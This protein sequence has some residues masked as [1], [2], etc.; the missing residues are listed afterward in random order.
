MKILNSI[1]IVVVALILMSPVISISQQDFV[2][3]SP[4]VAAI[5]KFIDVPVNGYTG[6]PSIN[7]PLTNLNSKSLNIPV[8]ISYHAGGVKVAEEASEVGL[9][10]SLNAGGVISREI[11]GEDDFGDFKYRACQSSNNG[12]FN[13]T[14]YYPADPDQQAG[15]AQYF[16]PENNFAM[17]F[18]SEET[19]TSSYWNACSYD[20]YSGNNVLFSDL[21]FYDQYDFESDIYSFSFLGESGKFVFDKNGEI[22]TLNNPSVKVELI[23]YSYWRITLPNGIEGTFGADTSS[24]QKTYITNNTVVFDG[25]YESCPTC[26]SGTCEEEFISAWKINGIKSPDGDE[27]LFNYVKTNKIVAPIPSYSENQ[28]QTIGNC[29]YYT[30]EGV[31]NSVSSNCN[32]APPP[33]T[34]TKSFTE[35]KYDRIE[36]TSIQSNEIDCKVDFSYATRSDLSGGTRLT[37]I[38]KKINGSVYQ[39]VALA[40]NGYFESLSASNNW[41]TNFSTVFPYILNGLYSDETLKKRLKLTSIQTIGHD[42]T[43]LPPTVFSYNDNFPIP[44]KASFEVDLWGFYNGASGNTSLLPEVKG[45]SPTIAN[46]SITQGL[47]QSDDY[48]N[49]T[50]LLSCLYIDEAGADREPDAQYASTWI[51]EQVQ[52]PSG[53]IQDFTFESN[54][55]K[56]ELD[57]ET[58]IAKTASVYRTIWS[59]GTTVEY[60]SDT[61]NTFQ[62]NNGCSSTTI[63]LV[64]NWQ[65]YVPGTCIEDFCNCAPLGDCLCST[66]TSGSIFKIQLFRNEGGAQTLIHEVSPSWI[67]PTTT[68]TNNIGSYES[69]TFS[70]EVLVENANTADSF[71]LKILNQWSPSACSEEIPKNISVTTVANWTDVGS[72]NVDVMGGGLRIESITETDMADG[73]KIKRSFDYSSDKGLTSGRSL[74]HPLSWSIN[75]SLNMCDSGISDADLALL[76]IILNRYSSPYK[77]TSNR[78]AG[79]YV[80]YEDV[81]ITT[82]VDYNQGVFSLIENQRF[83]I[84]SEDPDYQLSPDYE[85]VFDFRNGRMLSSFK[86]D[87]ENKPMEKVTYNYSNLNLGE[88]W[89]GKVNFLWKLSNQAPCY[90]EFFY[91][92]FNKIKSQ[93]VRLDSKESIKYEKD[94]G[95]MT[96]TEDYTY[97]ENYFQRRSTIVSNGTYSRSTNSIYPF[98]IPAYQFMVDANMIAVPLET[99]IDGG[100][101]GG[102]KMNFIQIGDAVLPST[103]YVYDSSEP[104]NWKQ[105]QDIVSYDVKLYPKIIKN[106]TDATT[107]EIIWGSGTRKGLVDQIKY[108]DRVYSFGYNNFRELTSSIDNNGIESTFSYDGLGRLTYQSSNNGRVS[109]TFNYTIDLV[110]GGENKITNVL[111]YGDGGGYTTISTLDGHGRSFHDRMVAYLDDGSNLD[112]STTHD[113]L[114]RK[115]TID[116]PRSGGKS[117]FVPYKAPSNKVTSV[118]PAGS[119]VSVNTLFTTDGTDFI[120]ETIDE[121]GIS[122]KVHTDIFGN[123]RKTIDGMGEA[124]IYTYNNRD[125]VTSIDPPGSGASYVYSYYGDGLLQSKTIPDKGS[126]IYTYDAFDQVATETLPNGKVVVNTYHGTYTDFLISR[127]VDG[128]LIEHYKPYDPTYVKDFIGEESYSIHTSFGVAGQRHEI[129]HLDI[130]QDFGRSITQ[131]VNTLDGE[132]LKEMSYDDTGNMTSNKITTTAF[133]ET[134]VSS[135][136]WTYPKG[137]RQKLYGFTVGELSGGSWMNYDGHDWLTEKKLG[138]DIQIVSYEYNPR[139]WLT[140]INGIGDVS[141]FGASNCSE[142]VDIPT[143]E[144]DCPK[145]LEI[146]QTFLIEYDCGKLNNG[147]PTVISIGVTSQSFDNGQRVGVDHQTITI[148]V[149]GASSE[150]TETLSNSFSFDLPSVGTPTEISGGI[151]ELLLECLQANPELLPILE[152]LLLQGLEDQLDDGDGTTGGPVNTSGLIHTTKPMFGMEIHYFDGNGKLEAPGRKNGNIS[153]IEWQVFG[154]TPNAYGFDY[155]D[156]NRLLQAIHGEQFE[157]DGCAIK[158]IDKYSVTGIGY[159]E[160]GNIQTLNRKGLLNPDATGG[161]EYK[162]IDALEYKYSGSPN[163]VSSITDNAVVDKGFVGG[164]GSYNYSGTGNIEYMSNK[165]LDIVYA[166]NDLPVKMTNSNGKVINYYTSTGLK[167]KTVMEPNEDAPTGSSPIVTNYFE[168]QEFQNSRLNSIYFEEGRATYEEFPETEDDEEYIEYFL[169]DHL[170]NTRVRIADKNGDGKVKYDVNNPTNDELMSKHH[171]YPFGM[172]WDVPNFDSNGNSLSGIG[173]KTKYTYNGKELVDDLD[174]NLNDYGARYYD[175]AIARFTTIDPAAEEYAPISGYSYVANNPIIFTDP[176]GAYIVDQDGNRVSVTENE[177]GSTSL[178]GNLDEGSSKILNAMLTTP[179]GLDAVNEMLISDD[180]IRLELTDEVITDDKGNGVHGMTTSENNENG[181]FSHY[182]I[183]VSTA[184]L[185]DDRMDNFSDEEKMNIIGVHEEDHILGGGKLLHNEVDPVSTELQSRFEYSNLYPSKSDK[186]SNWKPRYQ[187]YLGKKAVKKIEKKANKR[188]GN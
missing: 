134:V 16:G 159:D 121:D 25:Q 97:D 27:V 166:F 110:N 57:S 14:T 124:T 61:E 168:G 66:N 125:L 76:S 139:G 113:A 79:S 147:D 104:T 100:A 75:T 149:N 140:K 36:L 115:E 105:V 80:G 17:I 24:I 71:T 5:N 117:T 21:C 174:I 18:P 42:G 52:N 78:Y 47:I 48:Q 49:C 188:T 145:L 60:S 143:P 10:W 136:S 167:L 9:G 152:S 144:L 99:R 128:T 183:K 53:V 55:Y 44:D 111:A 142:P 15:T 39:T 129:Q 88:E 101:G 31:F 170:G 102:T 29:Q 169:K 112:I 4:E 137:L 91:L 68:G 6:I 131:K 77:G 95:S 8:S 58:T 38:S 34:L 32:P 72:A 138:N 59:P 107:R 85:G 156:N 153:W 133:D 180:E 141:S 184:N 181:E 84:Q 173:D 118:T 69:Y 46:Y 62:I 120:T 177:D 26:A 182:N 155:D 108:S 178:V 109:N 164:S 150:Q 65:E 51:L 172:E 98:D 185:G 116:D 3:P 70:Q 187:G 23:N 161:Y 74:N 56:P 7:I 40:N 160:L 67:Q 89:Y 2:P 73:K 135:E 176:T 171:Y 163:M 12:F 33:T 130:D 83:F 37:S 35:T 82:D 122:T 119:P 148:P 106:H 154:E 63:E 92:T 81:R 94:G 11:R 22:L 165:G 90:N 114:G 103:Q 13:S 30:D 20:T 186:K 28:S 64:A 41:I 96:I 45:L 50:D 126:H 175:P 132:Y 157:P 151:Y 158:K 93:W 87:G 162:T 19:C 179:T 123:T 127:E 146:I 1:Y 86:Y 43:S 54:S